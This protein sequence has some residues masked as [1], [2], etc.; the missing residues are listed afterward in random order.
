M[1][2]INQEFFLF[3]NIVTV[4]LISL[5]CFKIAF[6]WKKRK[7]LF[8][9]FLTLGGTYFLVYIFLSF[10][11]STNS[12]FALTIGS[13]MLSVWTILFSVGTFIIL[14]PKKSFLDYAPLIFILIPFFYF[15]TRSIESTLIKLLDI[16]AL[17]LTLI[18]IKLI[19]FGKKP[20]K[21]AGSIGIL[22]T[23]IVIIYVF[24]FLVKL[25][26]SVYV[27]FFNI[28]LTIFFI[29]LWHIFEKKSKYVLNDLE[30]QKL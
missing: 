15:F 18:F 30:Y 12:L 4:L 9:N 13:I 8:I 6:I 29:S 1:I 2:E 26:T 24:G 20:I 25:S 21:I 27:L 10:W 22:S 28:F 16:S 5:S 3:A 14:F 11:F 23:I 17:I 19:I 7:L